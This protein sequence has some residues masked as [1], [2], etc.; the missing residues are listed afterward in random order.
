MLY[1]RLFF[2]ALAFG[3]LFWISWAIAAANSLSLLTI[4]F[5]FIIGACWGSFA[6]ATVWRLRFWQLSEDKKDGA[7]LDKTEK[8][9]YKLLKRR[10]ANTSFFGNSKNINK[11]RSVCL[12]CGRQLKWYD[13]LPVVSWL[14]LG[15]KCR[16]CKTPIGKAE[17]LAEIGL[18]L[19]FA[20]SYIF[21]PFGEYFMP[22]SIP[23]VLLGL[24]WLI[25]LVLLLIHLVYD[26]KWML[27]LDRI[28]VMVTC[29]VLVMI[30]VQIVSGQVVINQDYIGNLVASLVVLPG[31]YGLMYF[32][33][34]GGWIGLGDVKLLVPL[35]LLLAD[36]NL[37]VFVLF[38]A[39]FLGLLFI[40]P[41]M[42]LHKIDRNSRV[43]FGPFLILAWVIAIIFGKTLIRHYFGLFG[44]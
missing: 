14:A 2:T 25:I 21:W 41:G 9:D 5:L 7:K 37:S 44:I 36:F 6:V 26:F 32:V 40:L 31:L 19:V 39:N 22:S 10:F 11:D 29:L 17:F 38:V 28:T 15:G 20:I 1:V 42:I 30:G 8:A 3:V 33:S 16:T 34:K 12:K 23:D 4:W 43:A 24:L 35:A 13:M 18:G 27:L